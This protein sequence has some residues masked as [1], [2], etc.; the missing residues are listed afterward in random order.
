[1]T[2]FFILWVFGTSYLSGPY[3]SKD[4]CLKQLHTEITSQKNLGWHAGELQ[5][6]PINGACFQGIN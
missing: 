4:V 2:W 6:L 3:D 5:G 1:M